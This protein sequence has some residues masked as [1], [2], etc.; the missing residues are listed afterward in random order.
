MVK[1][2]LYLFLLLWSL[3]LPASALPQYDNPGTNAAAQ[4]AEGTVWALGNSGAGTLRRWFTT[5]AGKKG[6]WIP[7]TIPGAAGFEA[8]VLTRGAD[9]IIYVFWQ[10]RNQG[11]SETSRCLITMHRGKWRILARFSGAVVQDWGFSGRP[12][13]WASA[14]GD[15]WLSGDRPLLRHISSQGVVTLLPLTFEQHFQTLPSNPLTKS[16]E[17]SPIYGVRWIAQRLS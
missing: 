13:L 6:T 15:V 14:D 3:A 10:T 4:D 12:T 8:R 1:T 2:L 17:V 9:G 16:A 5:D 11:Q 7:E